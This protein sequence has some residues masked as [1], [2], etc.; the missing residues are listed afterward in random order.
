M[1]LCISNRGLR[2]YQ[3][4]LSHVVASFMYLRTFAKR[5]RN[6]ARLGCAGARFRSSEQPACHVALVDYTRIGI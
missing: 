3:S 6:A 1:F 5:G 4:N 2:N